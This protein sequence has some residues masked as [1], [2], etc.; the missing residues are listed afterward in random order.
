MKIIGKTRKPLMAL[1]MMIAV[2]IPLAAAGAREE[3]ETAAETAATVHYVDDL[4]REMDIPY[5][6]E[7]LSPSGNLAQMT[8]YAL[9]PEKMVGLA[10]PLSKNAMDFMLD[11]IKDLPS[12]GNF[13]A[14]KGNINKEA[15]L[16]AR[17]DAF[18]DVGEI[19]PNM[20]ESFKSLE[21]Q[22]GIPVIFIEGF[23]ENIGDTIRELGRLTGLEERAEVL[24]SYADRVVEFAIEKR[25]MIE[26]PVT[27][28]YSSSPDGLDG[29]P[30]GSFH[31]EIV[32][33]V[34]LENVVPE[35]FSA[36]GNKISIEQLL[37]WNPDIMLIQN[38]DAY[39]TI[40]TDSRFSGLDA[41]KNDRVYLIPILPYPF[42]SNPPALNRLIGIFWLGKISY[43]ELYA[44]IDIA[45]EMKV[46]YDLFYHYE[47]TD[48]EIDMIL[49]RI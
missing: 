12:F 25:G 24:A 14:S 16:M 18:I 30:T 43:P 40:T 41:V 39:R 44:E 42:L 15:L 27:A 26:T 5:P 21:D 34:G 35:G 6:L 7:R 9:C 46:F 17:P 11:E 1:V 29:F 49:N 10:K 31:G 23:L 45:E 33:F 38:E 22:L 20:A 8:M 19:K 32:E 28:Y 4:G 2:I 36:G 37:L 47:L 48:P 3:V 13:F